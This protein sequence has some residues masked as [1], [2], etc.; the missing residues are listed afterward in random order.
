MKTLI[1][2]NYDSFTYN[3]AHYLAEANQEEPLVVRNDAM[4]WAELAEQPFDNIVISP[5]PGRPDRPADFG[6]SADAI[7]HANVPILGVC[8]G[9]QG[10]AALHGGAVVTAPAPMHGR[11]SRVWHNGDA[12]F[13]G[14]P[15]T[16]DVVRYH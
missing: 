12:L 10:I 15:A 14:V 1:I 8:L 4:S 13:A 9:H 7:S 3:L 5:G 2:D 16:F 6:L 11:L